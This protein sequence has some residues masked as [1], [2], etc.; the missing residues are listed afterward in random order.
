[1]NSISWCK[2][3]Y[4]FSLGVSHKLGILWGYWTVRE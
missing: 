1:M 4:L 3:L 2:G